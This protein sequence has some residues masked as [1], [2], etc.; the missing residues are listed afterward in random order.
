MLIPVVA[1]LATAIVLIATATLAYVRWHIFTHWQRNGFTAIA[2]QLPWGNLAAVMRR[3]CSFGVNIWQLYDST[4]AALCGVYLL[5]RPALLVRD[6]TLVRCMLGADFAHFHDRGVYSRPEADPISDN[7]FAMTGQRWRQLR[8]QLTPMFTS[9]RM[10][11]MLP[12]LLEKGDNLVRAL[13]TSATAD[14]SGSSSTGADNCVDMKDFVSR[15]E[16]SWCIFSD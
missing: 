13:E 4:T 6:P 7:L 15:Y 9:G 10:K 3:H 5:W 8:A 14:V 12:T 16:L 2:P 11:N 1:I